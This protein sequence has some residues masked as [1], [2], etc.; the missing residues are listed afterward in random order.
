MN[1]LPPPGQSLSRYDVVE[2][3]VFYNDRIECRTDLP[4]P[5]QGGPLNGSFIVY[6][7]DLGMDH[8]GYHVDSVAGVAWSSAID[9]I[10]LALAGTDST[11]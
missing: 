9:V 11:V 10:P 4:G 7:C 8:A 1:P 2:H 6:V 5:W 3:R